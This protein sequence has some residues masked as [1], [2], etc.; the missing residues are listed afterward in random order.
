MVFDRRRNAAYYAAMAR[1]IGPDTVVMDLG[2]GIG[3]LGLEAARLGARKVYLVDP[4]PVVNVAAEI[5]RANGLADRVE[6]INRPIE[7]AGIQEQVDVILSVFT[8]NF[9]LEEDLLPLLF[10]AR[11]RFLAP[12]GV[13]IPDRGTMLAAPVSAA[14]YYRSKVAAWEDP[15]NGLDLSAARRYAGNSVYTER[16]KRINPVLLADGVELATLDFHTAERASCDSSIEVE[17][18]REGT[19]HGLLGWFDMRLGTEWLSTSPCAEPTH[20]SQVFLP[21]LPSVDVGVGETVRIRIK[22][23]QYG[24]WTWVFESARGKNR[25]STFLEK[26]VL[27]SDMLK[28]AESSAPGRSPLGAAAALAL[29]L[30][31]GDFSVNQICDEL[32]RHH[33]KC[34]NSRERVELFVSSLLSRFA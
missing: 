6:I 4:S 20:W 15:G 17:A 5:A 21:L 32:E 28:T 2:A 7:S 24:N 19:C 31:A 3:V 8:G 13:L 12:G 26:P 25:Q 1:H 23:P 14:E 29:E 10:E 22:R 34:F 33:G 27:H 16:S 11:D 9:L 30:M 18:T